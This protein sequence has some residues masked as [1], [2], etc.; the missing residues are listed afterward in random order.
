MLK[1]LNSRFVSETFQVPIFNLLA[2]LRDEKYPDLADAATL[3]ELRCWV[4]H[5]CF[6]RALKKTARNIMTSRMVAK[7][8]QVKSK[9]KDEL[10][11][12]IRMRMALR[13][14]QDL[15]KDD[16]DTYAGTA[17]RL[18]QRIVASE[19]ACHPGWTACAFDVMKAFLQGLTYEEMAELTGGPV[20]EVH[21]TL[22]KGA[23][24]ILRMIPGYEDFD[25]VTECLRCTKPGTGTVEAPRAFSLKLRGITQGPDCAMKP[26]LHDEELEMKHDPDSSGGKPIL[27]MMSMK[28]VD[29][30]KVL[31]EPAYVKKYKQIVESH[32]GECVENVTEFTCVGIHHVFSDDGVALDQTEYIGSLKPVKHHKMIGLPA[33]AE[34]D[35]ELAGLYAS[36]LGALAFALMTQHW[37]AV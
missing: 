34:G 12:I 10:T 17:K 13:G 29:D 5:K 21:F 30:V 22:P 16:L 33:D 1:T 9:S 19:W 15:D 36:L 14:F 6:T 23:A 35:D 18:S 32:F 7:W 28:H 20:R 25:E 37:A 26:T 3:E 11:W 24:R 8:K 27:R 2:D 4:K 31:G